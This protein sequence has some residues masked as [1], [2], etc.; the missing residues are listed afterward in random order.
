MEYIRINDPELCYSSIATNDP[1]K[2]GVRDYVNNSTPRKNQ[3]GV[4]LKITDHPHNGR[5]LV[6]VRVFESWTQVDDNYGHD[7]VMGR[8]GID[9]IPYDE[10]DSGMETL[11]KM[12]V[13]AT[14]SWSSVQP[15]SSPINYYDSDAVAVKKPKLKAP[16]PPKIMKQE[17]FKLGDIVRVINRGATGYG[18]EFE[19]TGLNEYG[20]PYVVGRVGS[21]IK[22]SGYHGHEIEL[23]KRE[24][25]LSNDDKPIFSRNEI[26]EILNQ[27]KTSEEIIFDLMDHLTN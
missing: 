7:Y 6:S 23:V 3:Y 26:L 20:Y 13:A 8:D 2:Y 9:I 11:T 27:G 24:P 5:T 19:I 14:T 16:P 21:S 15:V 17:Y 1:D 10:F 12:N 4:I 22:M 18:K 25:E